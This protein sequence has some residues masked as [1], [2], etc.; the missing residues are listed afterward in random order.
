MRTVSIGFRAKTARA[1]AIALSRGDPVPAY[2]ARWEICLCDSHRP[3]T[4]QPH[5][6]GM[7]L[8]W[9][10]AQAAVQP[11]ERQIEKVAVDRLSALLNE[12]KSKGCTV[13][14]IGVVGSPDRSL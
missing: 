13:S 2:L 1:I 6:E 7:E 5:H 3:A 12:L 8:P 11:L 14:S 9:A 4:G 10:E